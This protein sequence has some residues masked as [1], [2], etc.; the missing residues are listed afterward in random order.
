MENEIEKKARELASSFYDQGD[1]KF[2][3]CK[4]GYEKG[5]QA[6]LEHIEKYLKESL[7]FHQ[8]MQLKEAKDLSVSTNELNFMDGIISELKNVLLNIRGKA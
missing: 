6:C 1:G 7:E 5:W 8:K 2:Y 3:A 4:R